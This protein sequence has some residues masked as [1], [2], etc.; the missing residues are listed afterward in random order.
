[1]FYFKGDLGKRKERMSGTMSVGSANGS[2]HFS[3]KYPWS[4][5]QRGS[6]SGRVFT[7]KVV[8]PGQMRA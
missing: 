7:L 2:Y 4:W 1:M 6:K 5:G 8:H 3:L